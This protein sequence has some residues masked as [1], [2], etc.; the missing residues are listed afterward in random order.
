MYLAV[1][2]KWDPVFHGQTPEQEF[3]PNDEYLFH[4][5]ISRDEFFSD[6]FRGKDIQLVEK[7]WRGEYCLAA[8]FTFWLRLFQRKFRNRCHI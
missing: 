6:T 1:I 7:C 2:E 4:F 5:K 8:R 3:M